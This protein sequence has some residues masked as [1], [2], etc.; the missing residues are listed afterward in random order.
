MPIG[1]ILLLVLAVPVGLAAY[2]LTGSILIQLGFASVAGGLLLVFLPLLVAGLCAV[3]LLIPFIDFNAK[4]A[5]ANRPPAG[6]RDRTR[7]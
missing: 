5:L 4:Q 6:D 1:R 7:D 3:P 2:L